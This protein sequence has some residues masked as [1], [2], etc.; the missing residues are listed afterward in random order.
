MDASA[1]RVVR[2]Y[3]DRNRRR[4][5]QAPALTNVPG[6]IAGADHTGPARTGLSR[7]ESTGG[8]AGWRCGRAARRKL[9]GVSEQPVSEAATIL[10]ELARDQHARPV[11]DIEEL[12]ADVWSSDEELDEFLADWRATR[13][14]SLS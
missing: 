6:V 1:R 5:P 2:A 13:D 11:R 3:A 10:E 4:W 14:S 8:C 12:R 9:S 7:R